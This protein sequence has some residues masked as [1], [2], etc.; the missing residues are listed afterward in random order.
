M[1]AKNI[2]A[3]H[4]FYTCLQTGRGWS[5]VASGPCEMKGDV[6]RLCKG[7]TVDGV[8]WEGCRG[9]HASLQDW[10]AVADVLWKCVFFGR[11]CRKQ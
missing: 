3:R 10:A 7:W 4:Y 9:W 2:G 5:D 1:F 8:G 11:N 6:G